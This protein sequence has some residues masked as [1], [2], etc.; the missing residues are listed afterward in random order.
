AELTAGGGASFSPDGTRLAFVRGP[1]RVWVSD[2][3]GRAA[4][5]G[6]NAEAGPNDPVTWFPNGRLAWQTPDVRNYRI[7]DLASGHDELLV[8]NPEMG[9]L[10]E[11]SFSPRGEQ[12]AVYWNR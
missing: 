12:V 10:F 3:D 9:W 6:K 7:R 8:N 2:A 11:P 4:Q 5:Q 1:Q